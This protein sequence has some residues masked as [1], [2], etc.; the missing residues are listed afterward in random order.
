M[1]IN[2]IPISKITMTD[3]HTMNIKELK[4]DIETI[5]S[6]HNVLSDIVESNNK[7]NEETH[8]V[9]FKTIATDYQVLNDKLTD[10]NSKINLLTGN[11]GETRAKIILLESTL[12]EVITEMAANIKINQII[13]ATLVVIIIIQLVVIFKM[14]YR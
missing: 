3:T 2:K 4:D 13:I 9:I 5:K 6:E 8:G 1:E 7:A 12:E 11:L 14:V 10:M